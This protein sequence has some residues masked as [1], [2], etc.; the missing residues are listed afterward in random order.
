MR[1]KLIK[2]LNEKHRVVMWEWHN[3]TFKIYYRDC[4]NVTVWGQVY[5][6]EIPH[7]CKAYELYTAH[8]HLNRWNRINIRVAIEKVNDML[9]VACGHPVEPRRG[10]EETENKVLRECRKSLSLE[11]QKWAE[12]EIHKRAEEDK[13]MPKLRRYKNK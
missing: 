4:G 3:K 9:D 13:C 8:V 2:R 7:Y 6:S 11:L 5:Q 12:E 10:W 1:I